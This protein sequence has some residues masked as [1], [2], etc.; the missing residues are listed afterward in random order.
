MRREGEG[1]LEKFWVF[2]IVWKVLDRRTV[3]CRRAGV[4][5]YRSRDLLGNQV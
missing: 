2:G 5:I 4:H 3:A 1:D